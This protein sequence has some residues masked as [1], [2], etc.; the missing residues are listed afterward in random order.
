M[1]T[2][3]NEHNKKCIL[4]YLLTISI[5]PDFPLNIRNKETLECEVDIYEKERA[6]IL[7]GIGVVPKPF[8]SADFSK[9]LTDIN[10]KF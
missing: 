1:P 7:A 6:S 10:C 4:V 3:H 5:V 2:Y 8:T 9:T